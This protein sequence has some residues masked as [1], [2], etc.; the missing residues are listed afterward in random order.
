MVMDY[1]PPPTPEPARKSSWGSML[2]VLSVASGFVAF[3]LLAPIGRI[4][5]AILVGGMVFPAI[6]AL[7]YFVW[8]RWIRQALE[9]D[10]AERDEADDR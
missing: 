10:L 4:G 8:G 1:K 2:L 6:I 5:I 9:R 7:H 3:L